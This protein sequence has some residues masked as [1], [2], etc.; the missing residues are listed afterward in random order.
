MRALFDGLTNGARLWIYGFKR[1]LQAAEAD[2]VEQLIQTFCGQ[3]R[4][5]GAPVTSG[6]GVL[7]RHFAMIAGELPDGN[8]SGCGID[9]SVRLFKDLRDQQQLDA[10]DHSLVHYRQS[11]G[12]IA[13]A[14][15]A[16]FQ[17]LVRDG[18]VDEQTPVFDLTVETVGAYREG[19]F[20]LPMRD[21]WH[22]NAF[23]ARA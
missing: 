3:W 14:N 15:R 13:T 20:E 10:L 12:T 1:D 7:E 18:K 5:H 19:C 6:G 2:Q 16:L 11:D 23:L 17:A 22:A 21:S 4:S 9:A 8:I